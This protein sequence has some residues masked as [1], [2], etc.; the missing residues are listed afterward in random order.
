MT[1]TSVFTTSFTA[2]DDVRGVV[3]VDSILNGTSSGGVRITPDVDEREVA[4][5]AAEMTYKYSFFGLPRGGAKCGITMPAALQGP[6]KLAALEDVGRHLAPL[7]RAN[8]YNPG[9]DMNC[10]PDD[11]RAIYRGAG[12][13]LGRLTD[14]SL[15]TAVFA[16][17]AVIA[18]R[19][20]MQGQ[21][22]PPTTIAIE[23]FGNVATHLVQL[24]PQKDFR[25]IAVS[26]ASG[27]V[28]NEQGL[29]I[30]ELL[31]MRAKHG[32]ALTAHVAGTQ[33]TPKE[34]LLHLDVDILIPAARVG[35]IDADNV[36][37]VQA[38][39][40]VPAANAPC[41]PAALDNLFERG[42]TVLPGFVCNAGGVL[43]SSL[44][45][46]GV[47]HAQ[48]QDIAAGPYRNV[49]ETLLRQCLRT[50]QSAGEL[51]TAVAEARYQRAA[52][53]TASMNFS[54]RLKRLVIRKFAYRIP[55]VRR[56]LEGDVAAVCIV[57]LT[58]L[59]DELASL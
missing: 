52:T 22:A 3:V 36:A 40:I 42:V 50:G 35:S 51:A 13:T 1:R 27:A 26:T 10:G 57:D 46:R 8:I 17:N 31:T 9:M 28:V 49:I 59:A 25:I 7:I 23:G 38:K 14:T 15:Y 11:L 5:L 21:D 33:L 4:A 43:G 20:V 32:D 2:Q 56:W 12:I 37:G 6:Q 24:L 16:A 55:K 47:P 39:H 19:N 29:N 30:D 44:F 48:V 34:A 41:T 54:D 58:A 18:C 45:D 53:R